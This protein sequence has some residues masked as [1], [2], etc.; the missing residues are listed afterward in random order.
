MTKLL[1]RLGQG[2]D[3]VVLVGAYARIFAL[4]GLYLLEKAC[5]APSS[6]LRASRAPDVD[7][8]QRRR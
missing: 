2:W 7:H 8:W 4:V 3:V 6:L 1:N 5:R